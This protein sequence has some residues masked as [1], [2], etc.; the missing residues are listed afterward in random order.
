MNIQ[1]EQKSLSKT[2]K[3]AD[4]AIKQE[5]QKR[6]TQLE[7]EMKKIE[8]YAQKHINPDQRRQWLENMKSI[9]QDKVD[10]QNAAREVLKKDKQLREQKV[11]ATLHK[12]AAHKQLLNLQ[13]KK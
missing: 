12:M 7:L 5:A 1:A 2:I 3:E 8:Q 10:V 13:G 11:A 6:N 4:E 9:L